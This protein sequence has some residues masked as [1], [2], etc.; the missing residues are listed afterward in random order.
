MRDVPHIWDAWRSGR[1]VGDY[2]PSTRVTVEKSFELRTTAPVLGRWKKGPARWFQRS[3]TDR[4]IETEIPNVLNVSHEATIDSD[5]GTCDIVVLNMVMP[6][7]GQQE[8]DPAQWGT[9]GAFTWDM[10]ASQDAR[11]R[12][13]HA[14]N[15][16]FGVLVPN[17]LIRIYQGFG[18]E[19]KTIREAVTDG[20]LVLNGVFLLDEV[21]VSTEGTI[22]LRGR[23]MAKLLVDQQLYPPLVPRNEYPLKYC[24]YSF[25]NFTIPPD[26]KLSA[27]HQVFTQTSEYATCGAGPFSSLDEFM[28]QTNS[29]AT[30]HPVTDCLDWSFNDPP[31]AGPGEI[32]HQD[33][34]WLSEAKGSAADTVWVE[35]CCGGSDV[36]LIYVHP[37]A[38][39]YQVLVSVYENGEWIPTEVA[40]QGGVTPQG[41][42]YVISFASN[43]EGGWP[44]GTDPNTYWLPRTYR[45]SRIRLTFTNLASV[46]EGGFRA[47]MRKFVALY[48]HTAANYPPLSFACAAYPYNTENRTGYWQ[49]RSNG[50]IYAFGDARTYANSSWNKRDFKYPI[51]AMNATVEGEGYWVMDY[52]GHIESYGSAQYYGDPDAD[53]QNLLDIVDFAISPAGGY[54][55]LHKDGTVDSYGSATPHGSASPTGTMPSGGAVIARSIEGHPT[56]DGYWVLWSDGT[57]EAFGDCVHHG[58]ANRDG[59]G[60]TEYVGSLR[61]THTGD[62]Y[63]I[64][65]GGGIVQAFG[66]APD[67]GDVPRYPAEKWVQGLC[68]DMMQYSLGTNG[69]AV[70]Y[71]DGNLAFQGDFE[72]FGSIGAGSGQLRLDGNYK[73]YSD[74]VKD[75]LLWSGWMLYPDSTAGANLYIPDRATSRQAMAE[76]IYRYNG[77]PSFTPTV[78]SFIDVPPSHEF[79]TAIEWCFD[80]NIFWGYSSM[81][82]LRFRPDEEMTRQSTAAVLYRES[83]LPPFTPAGQTFPD[84]PPDHTFYLEIEW[85]ASQGFMSFLYTGQFSPARTVSRGEMARLFY[86]YDGSPAYTPSGSRSFGDVGRGS[87]WYTWV[88]WLSDQGIAVGYTNYTAPAFTG[89]APQVYGGIESTG[90]YAKECLPEDMFDKRPVMDAIR[91]IKEVVGYVFYVDQEGGA[92]FESPNWWGL[93]NFSMSG[94]PIDVIPEIDELVQ[95][96]GYDTRYGDSETRSEI[97]VASA[98]PTADQKDTVVTRVVPQNVGDLKGIVKPA[99]WTNGAFADSQEQRVMADLI[100]M[101]TWFARRQSSVE[102]VANPL[103]GINDQV[104]VYERQTGEVYIHYVRGISFSHDLVS[105]DFTM[106]L[107]THWLGGS[108]YNRAHLFYACAPHPS[109]QGYWQVDSTG[110]IWAF[111]EAEYF[112]KNESDSHIEPV[113]AMR[114]SPTGDGYYTLD[115]SGKIITY[116][117]AVH[118]GDLNQTTNDV[119]DFALSPS[120][121]GYYVLLEDGTV[122]TFGDA[123][124]FGDAA[125]TGLMPSGAAVVCHSIESHPVTQ[126]YWVLWSDGTVEEFNL[127][128]HGSA[129]RV[130]FQPT[131]Y[132][133]VLRR[134]RDGDGY[135][136]L[137]GNAIMQAFGAAVDEGDG[138]A[139]P[140]V[141]WVYGLCWDFIPDYSPGASGY[142]IQHADGKLDE[143]GDFIH[144]GD[145]GG[146][147]RKLRREV[148]WALTNDPGDG[149][150]KFVVSNDIMKFMLKTS[151]RSAM[152]AVVGNFGAAQEP[153]LK[154][155]VT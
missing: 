15:D 153:T 148:T 88:E 13:A 139:Y 43:W 20:N 53:G 44:A 38:G 81:E 8:T 91:Q 92:R 1:Y 102:C 56:G 94:T 47:G 149:D 136:I 16:W 126:G 55:V 63:W 40:G 86:T 132:V 124:Y 77:S 52:S 105:G 18:G 30:G 4:Q 113:V 116:G 57:V 66:D 31:N 19:D 78:Q 26:P 133:G 65:S 60:V 107:T 90:A 5:A 108:S 151:S 58:D 75:L 129:N 37:Y 95:L 134:T 103:I 50:R 35:F 120:G 25:K 17:A 62:G 112:D 24:R 96:T 98:D 144:Q 84:V 89:S 6:E 45:A 76:F 100:A 110:S 125:P 68:W 85:A 137:S 3:T 69:Y 28:G 83:G 115:V 143:L 9:P 29:N 12:W 39:N 119:R 121:D 145:A 99:M 82:G 74:I 122:H 41:V 7:L 101:H 36:N 150:G 104:R 42:P 114:P 61:A 2:K 142:A 97:I 93:G 138:V 64:P 117:D 146:G 128:N 46:P 21:S 154:A 23:N 80:Q 127:T 152:N 32:Q 135:W 87:E 131:E 155:R 11:A 33:S 48:D 118:R 71:A 14:K 79:Y 70:Q 109:L 22:H 73:D 130:G 54:W 140:A 141:R 10:G 34:Y 51:L 123:V 67:L 147:N 111:G 72:Y 49:V 106:S 59:F 27:N